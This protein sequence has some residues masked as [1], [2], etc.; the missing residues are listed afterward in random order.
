MALK[1]ILKFVKNVKFDEKD[2]DGNTPLALAFLSGHH[3]FVRTMIDYK[4]VITGTAIY[5]DRKKFEY[6]HIKE[7]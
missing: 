5:I 1:S 2:S 4:A 6:D 7:L 3:K